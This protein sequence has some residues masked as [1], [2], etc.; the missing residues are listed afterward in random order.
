M[1]GLDPRPFRAPTLRQDSR[2][3]S[4]LCRN[5]MVLGADFRV[6][7]ISIFFYGRD[8]HD[9]L[10]QTSTVYMRY[11]NIKLYMLFMYRLYYVYILC[12][13][14]MYTLYYVYIHIWY[15]HIQYRIR[16]ERYICLFFTEK[17]CKS[18]PNVRSKRAAWRRRVRKNTGESEWDTGVERPLRITVVEEKTAGPKLSRLCY[19]PRHQT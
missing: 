13:Y 17:Q 10:R 3:L 18:K 9:T 15:I 2:D 5:E 14:T 19:S 8:L 11:A 6:R 7:K 12:I 16:L 4:V 1:P